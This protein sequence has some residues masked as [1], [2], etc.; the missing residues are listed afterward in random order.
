MTDFWHIG[1]AVPDLDEGM[2]QVGA[3]FAVTWRPIHE[4]STTVTDE[5]GAEHGIVCRFTFSAGGP[6]A[7]EMWQ[8]IPGTPLATPETGILHPHRILGRRSAEGGRA[9]RGRGI[10][11]LHERPEP[12][13]PPG[14]GRADARAVRPGARPAVPAGP[15]PGRLAAARRPGQLRRGLAGGFPAITVHDLRDRLADDGPER[16][17]GRP[18]GIVTPIVI[19]SGMA[20]SC[21]IAGSASVCSMVNAAPSPSARAATRRFCAAEYIALYR[22]RWSGAPA[23]DIGAADQ[24]NR[25]R[26]TEGAEQVAHARVDQP[27]ARGWRGAP[28]A[29]RWP[30]PR[31][32]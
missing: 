8:A 16:L 32:G 22:K 1:L 3:A 18:T 7:I 11:L 23:V 2:R 30:A 27:V 19:S 14:P 6:F 10:R 17:G 31:R 9:P 4:R 5:T 28:A 12:G 29:G 13:H 24:D 26:L 21:R 15:V 25:G 20:S